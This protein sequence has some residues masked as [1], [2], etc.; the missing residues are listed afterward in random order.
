M[1]ITRSFLTKLIVRLFAASAATGAMAQGP[2]GVGGPGGPGGPGG[3]TTPLALLLLDAQVTNA[4]GLT[5][6]QQALWTALQTADK[7][8]RAEHEAARS[9]LQTQ[10]ATQFASASPD[11]VALEKA[12]VAQHQTLSDT[13]DAISAQAV[14]LYASL[15]TGQQAIVVTAA[16]AR[17]QQAR[18]R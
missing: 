5:T 9:A 12:F 8:A 2:H 16:Q 11:L 6:A 1:T 4:L 7:N 18:L 3:L 15:S 14:A 17:Y 10:V 13:G